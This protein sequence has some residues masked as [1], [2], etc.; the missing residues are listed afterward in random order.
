MKVGI[1]LQVL[2]LAIVLVSAF[3]TYIWGSEAARNNSV[4]GLGNVFAWAIAP[5][6]FGAFLYGLGGLLAQ[7]KRPPAASGP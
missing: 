5:A 4:G 6:L 7:R 2:G 1:I 3:L